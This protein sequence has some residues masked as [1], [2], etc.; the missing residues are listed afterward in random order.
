MRKHLITRSPE[1]IRTHGEGWLDLERVAVVEV[2]SEDKDYPVESAF[3]SGDTRGWRAAGPGSQT[4]RLVFDQP[5]RLRCIALVFEEN[6]TARTQEFVLRWSPDGGRSVKE[7]VRQQWNFSPPESIREAEEYQVE[8][9]GVTALEL[10]INPH[11]GGGVARA[12]L[13]NFRLS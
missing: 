9:S 1:S 11:I 5:Q 8:L 12:S 13:K 4:I 7:I 10:V 2:T 6:E 3:A